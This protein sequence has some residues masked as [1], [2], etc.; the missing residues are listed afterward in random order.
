M[1]TPAVSHGQCPQALANGDGAGT[2]AT[3]KDASTLA[4]GAATPH[5]VVNVVLQRVFQAGLSHGAFGADLL[6]YLYAHPV[7]WKKDVG[8]NFLA[9]PPH[10]PFC[11]HYAL[12]FHA[13]F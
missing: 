13:P 2:T 1:S 6:R 12:P 7:T 10:H 5:T 11:F 4:L 8:C 3:T 9:L